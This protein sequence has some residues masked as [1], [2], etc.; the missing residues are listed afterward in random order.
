MTMLLVCLLGAAQL[1]PQKVLPAQKP[2]D[3]WTAK[4]FG[5][6]AEATGCFLKLTSSKDPAVR[7]EG[8]WGLEKWQDATNDFDAATKARPKDVEVRVRWGLLFLERFNRAEAAQLFEEALL[9]K[10]DYAPALLALAQVA[11]ESYDK[12]AVELAEKALAADPKL[13]EARELLARLAVE[14]TNFARAITEADKAIAA[15]PDALDAMAIRAAIQLIEEKPADEWFAKI[16]ARNPAYGEAWSTVGELLVL[17]RRYEDGIAS[18]REAVRIKPTLWEARSR[19][20]INLMRLG[21]EVEAREHLELCYTNGYRNA[22]TVNTLRL[23]DSYKNFETFKTERSIVRLHRKESE[24]LRPYVEGEMQRI[25]TAFDKKYGFKMDRPIQLELYPDH[26][27]FA[28]RTMGMPGLGALGVTFGDVVAMDSPSGRKAGSF[29]WAS[30]LWHEMSHVYS[31]TLTKFRVPRW[32]TEGLAVYEETAAAPDW[33]DRL[34]MPSILAIRDKKLL[35]VATLDR[36]FIRP[37]YPAQVVVSYFQAG[38]VCTYISQKWGYPKLIEILRGY[39]EKKTTPQV[40]EQVLSIKTEDFDKEFLTWIEAQNKDLVKGFADWNERFKVLQ[41]DTLAKNFDEVLKN[42]P[43]LRDLYPDFVEPLNPYECLYRA[44]T[45]KGDK[46]A[47]KAELERYS[48]MGGRDPATLKVLATLQEEFG[49]KKAAAAT[50]N[51]LNYI[52]PVQDE[53]LHR[54]LGTLWFDQG[55]VEGAIREFRAALALKPVDPATAHYNL[56]KAYNAYGKPELAQEHCYFALESAPGYRPAQQL[57][58]ELTKK[59]I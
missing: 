14:D 39:G 25:M 53:E 48:R 31:L 8:H 29:H 40:F 35:P 44:H 13:I 52:Y 42:G 56:A 9:T 6:T 4:K 1:A 51:R 38:R 12:K 54:R 57:L 49:E 34:D 32:F 11:S 45:D 17:N 21:R 7:A 16:R 27:D 30:T 20:G 10:A 41:K 59:G 24:V 26:E 33:G 3:C 58:L 5:R 47:A 50:L 22:A 55:N 36:G 23:M 43:A 46:K 2:A 19:L 15:S 37:A 18:F 28:V